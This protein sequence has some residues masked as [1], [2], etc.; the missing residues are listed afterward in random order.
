MIS[1][2][3]ERAPETNWRTGEP[4]EASLAVGWC[5]DDHRRGRGQRDDARGAT[6]V[7]EHEGRSIY[8]MVRSTMNMSLLHRLEDF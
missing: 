1:P 8:G 4:A 6:L 7:D 3:F 2:E 5:D